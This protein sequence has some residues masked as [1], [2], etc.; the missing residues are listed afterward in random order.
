MCQRT[1]KAKMSQSTVLKTQFG[2]LESKGKLVYCNMGGNWGSDSVVKRSWMGL[3]TCYRERTKLRS[4]HPLWLL[5]S[6]AESRNTTLPEGDTHSRIHAPHVWYFHALSSCSGAAAMLVISPN[7]SASA[8]NIC[9]PATRR[10]VTKSG[11]GSVGYTPRSGLPRVWK[12]TVQTYDF[13]VLRSSRKRSFKVRFVKAKLCQV[14]C[15]VPGSL[16]WR[17]SKGIL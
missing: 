10:T 3:G 16:I 2:T 13:V 4:K 9:Y 11:P 14:H 7:W 1:Q 15:S 17:S 8:I 6:P 5:F 12:I